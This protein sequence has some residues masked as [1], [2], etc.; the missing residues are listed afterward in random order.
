MLLVGHK[1]FCFKPIKMVI[2]VIIIITTTIIKN[3][4]IIVIPRKMFTVKSHCKSS[5]GSCDECS[6][7]PGGC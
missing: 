4:I 3:K 1:N 7:A 6:A 2:N 5:L